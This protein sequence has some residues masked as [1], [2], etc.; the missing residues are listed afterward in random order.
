M[1]NKI[2][3][4]FKPAYVIIAAF[5]CITFLYTTDKNITI[6]A[7]Q[8]NKHMESSY[9]YLD[10][11]LKARR[12][13]I[14]AHRATYFSEPE[15]SL[16]AINDSIRHKVDYAEIDVQETRDGVVVL[17]H[18]K[19]LKRLTGLDSEVSNL[20][21]NQIEKLNIASRY[22]SGHK[23]EKI[24]TLNEAIKRSKGK[25]KL[26]IE[27]KPY[28]NTNDLTRRVVEIINK[29]KFV[30]QCLVHSMSYRIL[31]EVKQLNPKIKTGYIVYRPMTNL[32]ALNVD[33]Y[34]VEQRAVTKNLVMQIHKLH[35]NIYS[36]TVD[37]PMYMDNMLKLHV[38][39][40]ITDKPS[41]LMD[42]KKSIH[43]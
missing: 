12:I 36:W 3:K 14:I 42:A 26:I 7:K 20:N 28:G 8:G 16:N 18:D 39:G 23:R 24:P 13:K 4:R 38:D 33:F 30:K 32:T 5:I 21:F 9:K 1:I 22:P 6:K 41:I 43:L 19:N 11:D 17:M 29:N 25:L 10:N 31:L 34:S 27:I 35:R 15:N 40:I 2:F 37:K